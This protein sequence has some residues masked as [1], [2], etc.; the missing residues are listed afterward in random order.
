MKIEG[1]YTFTASCEMVWSMLLNPDMLFNVIPGCE[2]LDQLGPRQFD[3]TMHI[4]RGPLAGQYNGLVDLHDVVEY[5]SLHL[6]VVGGGPNGS[7]QAYGHITLLEVGEKQ[8]RLT[9]QGELLLDNNAAPQTARLVQTTANAQLRKFFQ[10]LEALIQTQTMVYTT[11]TGS[12]PLLETAVSGQRRKGKHTV[13][14]RDKLREISHNRRLLVVVAIFTLL[15]L[16]ALIGI[17]E[18]A[19]ALVYWIRD[20]F[21]QQVAAEVNRELN[22]GAQR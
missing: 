11:Y 6:T 2:H 4:N 18:S 19:R 21:A 10:A 1:D 22:D 13:D 14:A 7:I 5:E 15:N 3:L 8:I 12:E 9:Y 16:L 17:L 20:Y